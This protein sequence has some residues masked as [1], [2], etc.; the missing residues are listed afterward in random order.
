MQLAGVTEEV[1]RA[2]ASLGLSRAMRELRALEPEADSPERRARAEE[3]AVARVSLSTMVT[4]RPL[5]V[6]PAMPCGW[7]GA[8]PAGSFASACLSLAFAS[9]DASPETPS[10]RFARL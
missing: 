7:A 1:E 4:C 9:S 3:I 10:V 5:G 8:G 6:R 2:G